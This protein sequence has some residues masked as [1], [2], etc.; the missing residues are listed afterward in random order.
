[1]STWPYTF[2]YKIPVNNASLVAGFSRYI[3][4]QFVSL[5][6]S[7]DGSAFFKALR[8]NLSAFINSLA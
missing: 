5:V 2:V 4:Y 3:I 7:Y 6:C 8:T 1:M